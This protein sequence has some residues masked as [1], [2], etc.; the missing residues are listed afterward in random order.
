MSDEFRGVGEKSRDW[1]FKARHVLG[2][3]MTEH[4]IRFTTQIVRL[5]LTMVPQQRGYTLHEEEAI[6][7]SNLDDLLPPD[8]EI[9]NSYLQNV[10]FP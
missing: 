5:L 1:C 6:Y 9:I 4:R 3:A 10:P 7:R 8:Q 2:A